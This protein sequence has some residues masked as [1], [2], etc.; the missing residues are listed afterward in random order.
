MHLIVYTSQYTGTRSEISGVLEDIV[1]AAKANNPSRQVTGVLFYQ[2]G[3][4]VQL[5]EGEEAQLRELVAV[6]ERDPRHTD[7]RILLDR[8]VQRRGFSDWNMDSFNLDEETSLDLD[9]L[10]Q[11]FD[12]FQHKVP[13]RGDLVSKTLKQVMATIERIMAQRGTG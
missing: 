3:R 6:I 1:R 2:K 9:M 8:E 13:P 11:V 5:I 10:G 7:I 12:I 4:F